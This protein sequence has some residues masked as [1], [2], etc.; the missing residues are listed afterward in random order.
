MQTYTIR[1]PC[2]LSS[3]CSTK[4]WM[5]S[6][7]CPKTQSFGS[8]SKSS[9]NKSTKRYS[10]RSKPLSTE[11]SQNNSINN[12]LCRTMKKDSISRKASS[13]A[14]PLQSWPPKNNNFWT[15]WHKWPKTSPAPS[16]HSKPASSN[17]HNSSKCSSTSTNT[18][19]MQ[20]KTAKLKQ[21]KMPLNATG[22]FQSFGTSCL[23]CE[24]LCS[25]R[26]SLPSS[27]ASSKLSTSSD[28]RPLI[29]PST[30]C[31][32]SCLSSPSPLLRIAAQCT[33]QSW[34]KGLLESLKATSSAMT[35]HLRLWSPSCRQWHIQSS[36]ERPYALWLS[37]QQYFRAAFR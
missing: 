20:Y 18:Q 14:S 21:P 2:F 4:W 9:S 25:L 30:P 33:T 8:K 17:F 28:A 37:I 32:I 3:A 26:N 34:S 1:K 24:L 29:F 22:T 7:K 16:T 6:V 35:F 5:R 10:T 23:L 31:R 12:K 19:K 15:I 11:W 13:K 36:W 27:K